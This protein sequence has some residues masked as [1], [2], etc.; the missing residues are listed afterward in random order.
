MS[1]TKINWA[2]ETANPLVGCTKI[3]SGCENCYAI[4]M[5]NRLQSMGTEG[6]KGTVYKTPHGKLNWT[7]EINFIPKRLEGAAK[8]KKS[9]RI[10]VNSMSDLFHD[11]VTDEQ[12]KKI[13]DIITANQQHTF[14][15][16]TKRIKRANDWKLCD[17]KNLWLG[18]SASNQHDLNMGIDFLLQADAKIKWLSIEPMLSYIY[19]IPKIDWIVVGCESGLNRRP[20]YNDWAK[21][22]INTNKDIPIWIKQIRD[23][24]NNVIDDINLFPKELQLR[25]LPNNRE[26]E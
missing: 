7:G 11:K 4:Q 3:A 8:S 17:I 20:F 24:K 10:F 5:A 9:L 13:L 1:K 25:Q 15:I 22:I 23:E 16:L 2:D 6:Y 12:I 26:G 21:E 18:Y 19:N 14:L